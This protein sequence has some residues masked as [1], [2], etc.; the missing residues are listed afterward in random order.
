MP[1]DECLQQCQR[2]G[3]NF[4]VLHKLISNFFHINCEIVPIGKTI[5][6][7]TLGSVYT[8]DFPM[9]QGSEAAFETFA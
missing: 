7:E 5:D 6:R 3:A 2:A 8:M 1:C 9:L 4:V